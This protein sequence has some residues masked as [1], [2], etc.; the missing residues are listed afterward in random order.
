MTER[1][2]DPNSFLLTKREKII[3]GGVASV[4]AV[5][6]GIMDCAKWPEPLAP[7][8]NPRVHQPTSTNPLPKLSSSQGQ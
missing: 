2:K 3:L 8:T 4:L 5:A 7:D 1:L 6:G